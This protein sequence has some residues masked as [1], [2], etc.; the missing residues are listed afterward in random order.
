MEKP[1]YKTAIGRPG[2]GLETL[3]RAVCTRR[4]SGRA[5][6]A[7]R[8]KKLGA[9]RARPAHGLMALQCHRTRRGRAPVRP[10]SSGRDARRGRL[11]ASGGARRLRRFWSGRL[12]RRRSRSRGVRGFLV[13][14][15][16]ARRMLTTQRRDPFTATPQGQGLFAIRTLREMGKF[17]LTGLARAWRARWSTQG[18]I[19]RAI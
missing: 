15:S 13:A 14:P 3:A 19:C 17:A 9:L 12:W 5:G 1:K 16:R 7:A 2:E 6:P 4:P 10:G 18:M 8:I 11:Q